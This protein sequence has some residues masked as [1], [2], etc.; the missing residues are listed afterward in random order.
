MSSMWE[1]R[2]QIRPPFA[3]RPQAGQESVWDYPRPPRLESLTGTVE[4]FTNDTLMARSAGTLRVLETAS[5]P[6]I[7]MP[8][9]DIDMSLLTDVEGSSFCEWKGS[10]SYWKLV[11]DPADIPVA[12]SYREPFPAFVKIRDFLCFYPGRIACYIDGERVQAQPGKFYG[13]WITTA[14]TGPFKGDPGSGHW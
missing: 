11:D 1:Y 13:G 3:D 5:P 8:Q 2:G 14:I 12:W 10:A 6:T 9:Q 4:V 7:Y